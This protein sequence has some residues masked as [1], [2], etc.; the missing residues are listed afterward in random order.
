MYLKY[1]HLPIKT[2]TLVINHIGLH[3]GT[4]TSESLQDQAAILLTIIKIKGIQE[5]REPEQWF[6]GIKH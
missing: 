1:K 2:F 4:C 6:H 5:M 3:H